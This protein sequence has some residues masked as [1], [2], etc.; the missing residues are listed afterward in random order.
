MRASAV[1][2]LAL[3]AQ[4]ALAQWSGWDY[5][6]DR[7]VERFKELEVKLPEYPQADDLLSFDAGAASSHEF[8]IDSK[9]LNVG[10]DG[11]VRYTMVVKTSGGTTNVSYEGMRCDLRQVK[12]YATGRTNGTWARARDSQWTAIRA[13]TVNNQHAVLFRD[14][15]CG[16]KT[17]K[18][19]VA[20]VQEALQLLRTGGPEMAR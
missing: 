10:T 14:Y 7:P 5:N 17:D 15:F 11:V 1:I 19:P 20:R 16:L 4:P 6:N 12:I 9:S 3:L 13:R 2:C 18:T 8:Y